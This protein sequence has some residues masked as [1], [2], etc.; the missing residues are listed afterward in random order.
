MV[1]AALVVK[2]IVVGRFVDTD[3]PTPVNWKVGRIEASQHTTAA[4]SRW[5]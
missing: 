3:H 5:K 2:L 4:E 1:T